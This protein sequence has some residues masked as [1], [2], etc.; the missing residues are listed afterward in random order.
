M[1]TAARM[2]LRHLT[3]ILSMMFTVFLILDEFNPM[4][5]FIDCGISRWLLGLF[6]LCGAALGLTARADAGRL[7]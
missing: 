3:V 5:D 2:T 1:R 4:M 6:C 7:D